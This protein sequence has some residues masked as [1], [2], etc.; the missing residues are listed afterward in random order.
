[1]TEKEAIII[2]TYHNDWR[3]GEDIDMPN[4]KLLTQAIQTIINEYIKR[5][6][7]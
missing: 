6:T 7:K 1:M 5:T 3:L 4:P 2:L